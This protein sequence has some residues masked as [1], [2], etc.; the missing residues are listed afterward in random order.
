MIP[1]MNPAPVNKRGRLLWLADGLFYSKQHPSLLILWN[2]LP[3]RNANPGY[4]TQIPATAFM[5]HL[6]T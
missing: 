1:P 5:A 4:R 6:L 2:I 3:N